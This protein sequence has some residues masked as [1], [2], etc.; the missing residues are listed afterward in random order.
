MRV[1]LHDRQ[2]S[3]EGCEDARKRSI[4]ELLPSMYIYMYVAK[5]D[6]EEKK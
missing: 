6:F 3:E 4:M 5:L 2:E 1:M